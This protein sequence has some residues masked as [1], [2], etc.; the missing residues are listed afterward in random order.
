[1][2]AKVIITRINGNLELKRERDLDIQA[3][4]LEILGESESKVRIV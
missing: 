1:V 3:E 2:K 4:G